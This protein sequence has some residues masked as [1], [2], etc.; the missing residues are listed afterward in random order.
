[1]VHS[2]APL[3]KCAK[4]AHLWSPAPGDDPYMCTTIS[5][6]PPMTDGKM[7]G[8]LETEEAVTAA[9]SLLRKGRV[10]ETTYSQSIADRSEGRRS[11]RFL[12]HLTPGRAQ[13]ESS[14]APGLLDA[15]QR[16][17]P[18]ESLSSLPT[19]RRGPSHWSSRQHTHVRNLWVICTSRRRGPDQGVK[20]NREGQAR[21]DAWHRPS[22]QFWADGRRYDH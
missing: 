13:V 6:F 20:T 3:H 9:C 1:M 17:F 5:T 15:G 2:A 22:P 18:A 11:L 10:H 14:M 4:P 8:M 16:E 21:L 19:A 7:S 12:R